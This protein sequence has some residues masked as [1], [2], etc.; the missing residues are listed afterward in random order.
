MMGVN[1]HIVEEDLRYPQL[2]LEG[3]WGTHGYWV[4]MDTGEL[5]RFCVC[6]AHNEFEC[7]C[8][9]WEEK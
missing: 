6:A 1:A 8:G 3:S 2:I 7:M 5:Q 4:D 9:V